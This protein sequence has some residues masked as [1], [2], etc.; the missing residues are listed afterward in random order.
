M[1]SLFV[2]ELKPDEI[3]TAIFLVSTKEVRQKR[4]GEPYLSLVLSDR[5]GEIDC[6]MWDNVAEIIETFDRDDFVKVKGLMQLYNNRP[7]LTI[8]KLRRVEDGEVDFRDFFPASRQDA[9]AM[10]TELRQIVSEI[11]SDHIRSLLNAFLDDSDVAE[12]YKVAP[13]AKNI[14][15]AFR[16]GL[17]EHV[18]SL[19][20]LAR[21]VSAHYCGIEAGAVD[22]DLLMAGI[23]LHDIGK[24][25]E[26]TYDRG[27][28]YSAEGQLL[29]HIA[30]GIRMI[31]DKLRAL[32]GFPGELRTLIEHLVL[33]H[34]GQLEFGSPKLP[35]FPEALLL[36]HLDDLDSKMENMR[37][38][39]ERD[40]QA[41]GYF[42]GYSSALGRV[43]L[44]KKRFLE[45][46]PRGSGSVSHTEA[47]PVHNNHSVTASNE[48]T[49]HRS[50]NHA[51]GD[52]IQE[53]TGAPPNSNSAPAAQSLF[54]AK[55]QQALDDERK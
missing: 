14:H 39:I 2:R 24:I 29:G 35:M 47:I 44:R 31:G 30:I 11:R 13:A 52:P 34:H 37:A 5:T 8:H 36:H 54:G 49:N 7:Q 25:Y 10:W 27:F 26:L 20:K 15:H 45:S 48:T 18:L 21:V 46:D 12:R 43:A 16:G 40:P 50:T 22:V 33:S 1:K 51:G 3:S 55:L 4:T 23:V 28:A 9:D 19:L 42:T 38:L 41:E 17:L 6:K 32:P 53:S